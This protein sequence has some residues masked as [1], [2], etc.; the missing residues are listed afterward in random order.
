VRKSVVSKAMVFISE[1]RTHQRWRM[2]A[3]LS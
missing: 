3:P 2:R 1:T